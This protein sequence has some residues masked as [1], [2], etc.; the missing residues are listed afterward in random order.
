MVTPRRAAT[1]GATP[2]LVAGIQAAIVTL[3]V[4]LTGVLAIMG[5]V[6]VR[7]ARRIVTPANRIADT[8]ILGLDTA[9]QTITL[10][11]TP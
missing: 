8:K 9:A 2:A 5:F 6:S 4:A 1:R 3:G 10:A 7:F 11:R